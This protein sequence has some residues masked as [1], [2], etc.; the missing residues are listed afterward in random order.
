MNATRRRAELLHGVVAAGLGEE[1]QR[2][3]GQVVVL[4]GEVVAADLGQ[5]ERARR[6]PAATM[7]DGA[8]LDRLDGPELEQVVQVSADRGRCQIEPLR[9]VGR[10]GGPVLHDGAGHA[11]AR[12]GVPERGSL[13]RS[14]DFHNTSVTLMPRPVQVRMA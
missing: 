12:R 7:G 2:L 6:S 1:P 13:R 3:G 11:L 8:L 14:D 9:K 10:R 5:P 4:L